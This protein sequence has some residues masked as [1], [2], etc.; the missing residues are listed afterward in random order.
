[1]S[2]TTTNTAPTPISRP[3]FTMAATLLVLLSRRP[4]DNRAC[5]PTGGRHHRRRRRTGDTVL[6]VV[7]TGSLRC[8]LAADQ[9]YVDPRTHLIHAR[10]QMTSVVAAMLTVVG[11][12][13]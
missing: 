2:P 10:D 1:M 12:P 4:I 13:T 5:S 3:F 8:S 9:E 11:G 6:N 7:F